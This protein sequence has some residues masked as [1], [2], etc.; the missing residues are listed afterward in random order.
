M[1]TM[2]Q[3]KNFL[4]KDFTISTV[5]P[6]LPHV[7]PSLTPDQVR[8]IAKLCRLTMS[9]EE[10]EKF[11]KELTS[12]LKYIDRLQKVDTKDVEPLKNVTGMESVFRDDEFASDAVDPTTLIECTP[13]PVKDRQIETP[14]A[15]GN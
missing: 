6:I 9:E 14:S 11:T 1:Q 4:V 3:W 15:H 13:L 5:F 10:V 12:I 2:E 8:H 7:M